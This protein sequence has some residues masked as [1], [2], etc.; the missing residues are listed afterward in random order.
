MTRRAWI[1]GAAALV[2]ALAVF[3]G[4]GAAGAQEDHSGAVKARQAYMQLNGFYMGRLAAIAKGQVAYDA[5][6]A[7]GLANS[8]L[9]LAAMDV[10]AMWP[11]GSGND[12]P[13]LAGKTPGQAGDLDHLPGGC[14]EGRRPHQ[15]A[16]GD[17]GGGR[18][19]PRQPPGCLRP[20]RRRLRRLP[21]TLPRR[22]VL[23]PF[24][25]SA[26]GGGEGPG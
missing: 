16:G 26:P 23:G 6:Q 22:E 1:S 2:M 7:S 20:G 14:R 19:R 21:Q 4:T 12:N 15:G 9:T 24:S 10:G 5:A 13:A 18:H 11:G 3:A 8:L 17:G 25:L